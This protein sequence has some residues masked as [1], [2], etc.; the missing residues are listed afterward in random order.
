M[1]VDAAAAFA[2]EFA[3]H[4]CKTFSIAAIWPQVGTWTRI[5]LSGWACW[6]GYWNAPVL[7]CDTLAS[8]LLRIRRMVLTTLLPHNH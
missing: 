2:P 5:T 1:R 8:S 3:V 7:G 6:G 4:C